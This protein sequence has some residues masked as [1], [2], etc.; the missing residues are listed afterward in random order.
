[1]YIAVRFLFL[2]F[3]FFLMEFT[4]KITFIAPEEAIGQNLTPK[5]SCV[6]E[7]PEGQYPSSMSVDFFKEKIDLIKPYKVGE[8]VKVQL[9]FRAREYN[10]KYFNSISAWKI[11]KASASTTTTASAPATKAK[12]EAKDD[13]PF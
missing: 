5:V 1:M 4:G 9:N 3:S 10:G 11:E 13:L 2:L 8:V 12:P 6:L 7:E